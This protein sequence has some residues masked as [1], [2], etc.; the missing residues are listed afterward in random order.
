MHRVIAY[1]LADVPVKKKGFINRPRRRTIKQH[2]N[3][4]SF[5]L[6]L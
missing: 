4:D 2:F 1:H 3:P 5:A 6:D